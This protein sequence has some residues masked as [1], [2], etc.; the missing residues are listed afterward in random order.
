VA[1]TVELK[2][3]PARLGVMGETAWSGAEP[4]TDGDGKFSGP[5]EAE[6]S[7]VD[8]VEPSEAERFPVSETEAWVGPSGCT[9]TVVYP[10]GS[11][12]TED[13]EAVPESES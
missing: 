6:S 13:D 12:V 8:G 10:Y 5:S 7:G 2:S 3:P 11:T 9:T 4:G 1:V